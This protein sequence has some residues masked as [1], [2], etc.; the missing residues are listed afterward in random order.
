MGG[1]GDRLL[2]ADAEHTV[3]VTADGHLIG[4]FTVPDTGDCKQEGRQEPL[5][6]GPYT[7]AYQ[8]TPC[9]IAEFEVTAQ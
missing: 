3:R 8:C 5:S 4:E 1:G 7:I 9:F 6:S 2:Y